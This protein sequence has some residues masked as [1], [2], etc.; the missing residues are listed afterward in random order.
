MKLKFFMTLGLLLTALTGCSEGTYAPNTVSPYN[1]PYG[2][3]G[4]QTGFNNG[5]NNFNNGF[6]NGF[7]NNGFNNFNNGF[8]NGSFNNGLY[9]SPCGITYT[10]YN[11]YIYNPCQI[12][13]AQMQ[14][15]AQMMWNMN[16]RV[17]SS[18]Y[19]PMS[20]GSNCMFQRYPTYTPS[21]CACVRAPCDCDS[22]IRH[23]RRAYTRTHVTRT[24]STHTTRTTC[25]TCTTRS[26]DNRNDDD[27]RDNDNRDDS[28][29]DQN[30]N[31]DIKAIRVTSTK[32]DGSMAEEVWKRMAFKA[33]NPVDKDGK[34]EDEG[35]EIKTGKGLTCTRLKKEN[36]ITCEFEISA[37]K[38]NSSD[39]KGGIILENGKVSEIADAEIPNGNPIPADLHGDLIHI[40][41][42]N[43]NVAQFLMKGSASENVSGSSPSFKSLFEALS[44]FGTSTD[45]NGVTV[46]A[47]KEIKCSFDSKIKDDAY[48]CEVRFLSA[49]GAPIAVSDWEKEEYKIAD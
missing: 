44:A 37:K 11:P 6:N 31:T 27:S 22:I 13:Q 48:T 35:I 5:F 8:N 14:L 9:Q 24:R 2:V 18:F 43:G 41:K 39:D 45:G 36:L 28:N 21:R 26:S 25:I 49:T 15:Q 46:A 34:V 23:H 4:Y 40:L 42:R 16:F 29:N 33:T 1:N 17:N 47:G 30:S 10:Y 20:P 3:N 12:S 32:I 7:N 38:R 19:Y